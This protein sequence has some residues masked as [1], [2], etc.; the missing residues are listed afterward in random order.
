MIKVIKSVTKLSKVLRIIN[1]LY[2]LE[3]LTK[4]IMKTSVFTKIKKM[5]NLY[6]SNNLNLIVMIH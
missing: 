6:H 2:L 1:L 4:L 3:I 5:L